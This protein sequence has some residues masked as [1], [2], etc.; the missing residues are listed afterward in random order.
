MSE[1]KNAWDKFDILFKSL[2]L[3]AIP[4]VIGFAANHV[5][6]SL[7]RGQLIQSLV[8]SLS[9][10]DA[11][12]DIALIALDEAISP[13]KRCEV[14]WMWRCEN[15]VENDPVVQ[16]SGILIE[17][18]IET[19]SQTRQS[20]EALNRDLKVAARIVRGERRGDEQYYTDNY[21]VLVFNYIQKSQSQAIAN[22]EGSTPSDQEREVQANISQTIAAIQPLPE[23]PPTIDSLAGVRLVYIQ[24]DKNEQ[25]AEQ[26]QRNLQTVPISAPGIEQVQ[27]IEQNNIR[28]SNPTDRE[29]AIAL[30]AYL[31]SKYSIQFS[32]PIDLS[33]AGYRVSPG[34]FEIWLK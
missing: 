20:P 18:S 31:Q 11:R 1:K 15:D 24:Y 13:H 8:E 9:K 7:Q 19:A 34:Q 2:V 14:F 33:A 3:G 6:Q 5:A 16:I 17:S 32:D 4:I 27:G 28:Y 22:R 29:R 30:Q 25:L 23:K 10:G 21:G 26:I 12:R